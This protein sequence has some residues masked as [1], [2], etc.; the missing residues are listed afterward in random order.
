[1]KVK[2]LNIID[3][4]TF[5][6]LSTEYKK[7]FRYGKYVTVHKNYLVDSSGKKVASG[8][9]VEIVSCRPLSKSKSWVL[10]Q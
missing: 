1:M 9:E 3:N 4:K 7:H 2:V 10:K 5:K 6:A 8:D